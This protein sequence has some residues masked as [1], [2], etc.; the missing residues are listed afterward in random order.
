MQN[1]FLFLL[2]GADLEMLEIRKVLTENK[3][4]CNFLDANLDWGANWSDYLENEDYRKIIIKYLED[5]YE[6]YG[7]ELSGDVP[8]NFKFIDHH[9]EYQDRP[10]SIEQIADILGHELTHWQRLVAA[11]DRGYIPAMLQIGATEQEVQE[12]RLADR[13]AQGITT[14]IE[15]IAERDIANNL[16]LEGEVTVVFSNTNK[17]STIADRLLGKTNDRL[18]I[19]SNDTLNYYGEHKDALVEWLRMKGMDMENE[20]YHGGGE[21]GFFGLK[22]GLFSREEIENIKDQ[23]TTFINGRG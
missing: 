20:A 6:I 8:V 3:D 16:T 21:S 12:V 1:K 10:S 15:S 17:F 2:G 5:G 14:E 4:K 11:N 9:N 18:L 23:I 13:K 19:Y 22:I 7:I